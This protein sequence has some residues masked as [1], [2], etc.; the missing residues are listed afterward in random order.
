MFI[1]IHGH[2]YRKAAPQQPFGQAFPTPDQ[3]L[4]RYDRTGIERAVLLPLVSPEVYLPQSNEDI[5]EMTE[6]A[7]GRFIPFC[8]IDPR[9][10]T[11]SADAP[12]GDILRYYRDLGCK[13]IGE[14]MPNLPFLHPMVQNLFKHVEDVGFPLTFDIAA[15]IGGTYGLYDDAGLPQLERSLRRF[16]K[17]II[18]GH[19]PAFWAEIGQLEKPADRYGYPEYPIKDEGV[20]PKLL[21]QY[22][23][24]YGDLSATSGYNALARDPDHAVKFINE[25]RDRLLF[26]TDI[27]TPE[28]PTPLV[29]FLLE[30]RSSNKISEEVFQKIAR[31]NAIRML[32]LE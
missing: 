28:A 5:L 25:F 30:L 1:D 3:L 17:L 27:C 12:L 26:G 13:G 20:V 7:N 18:F 22:P 6:D 15:Q 16:P 10:M 9:A 31:G 2:A 29:D 32:G 14:V 19:G 11:N 8:N 23:N 21:R 4:E 24:L